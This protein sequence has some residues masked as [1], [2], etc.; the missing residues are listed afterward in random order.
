M[1]CRLCREERPLR[2]SHIIPEFVY[3]ALYDSKHKFHVL[4]SLKTRTRP[5]EQ[6]GLR[7]KL[8]C[9]KCESQLSLYEKYAREVLLGGQPITV[10]HIENI[11]KISDLDYTKF[12]LFQLSILWRASVSSH[13]MF[14]R[15]VLGPHEDRL[16]AMITNSDPGTSVDYPCVIFGLAS[17]AGVA[18][19]FIDQPT[20]MRLSNHLTYRFIFSGFMWC[21]FV[22]SHRLPPY[23]K[24]VAL[25]ETGTMI[26][27]RG[28][29][30]E[31]GHLRRFAVDLK[32][33]GRMN[34]PTE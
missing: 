4:S 29:F 32:D 17:N 19:N 1:N 28:P 5:K 2:N 33:L 25:N 27:G 21:F 34:R 14:S 9:D 10:Q 31:L 23:V 12:K 24:E 11:L 15:V 3:S 16:R 8:L 18:T 7:E 13:P 30:E 26:L 22:S 20:K 6:K